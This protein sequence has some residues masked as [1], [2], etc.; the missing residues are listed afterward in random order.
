MDTAP[1]LRLAALFSTGRAALIA[2]YGKR[3]QPHQL[4]AMNAILACRTGLLGHSCPKTTARYVHMT[5]RCRDN[6]RVLIDGL[7]TELHEVLLR[8]RSR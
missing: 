4:R 7:M 1:A 6:R 2:R 3:L 5:D 8:Q